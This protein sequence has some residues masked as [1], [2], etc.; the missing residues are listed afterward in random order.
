MPREIIERIFE[1]F[2]STKQVGRGTGLGLATVWHLISDLGGRVEVESAEGA[3]S[4]FYVYMPVRPADA[5]KAAPAVATPAAQPGL[6]VLVAEDEESIATVLRTLLKRDRHEVVITAN[7]RE[8]WE[9]FER[10]PGAF[11]VLLLDFNMPEVTGLELARRVRAAGYRGSLLIMSGRITEDARQQLLE[12][13]V[14]AIVE[15]P[16]TLD[17]IR[18]ALNRLRRRG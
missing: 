13:G 17:A 14:D 11:D 8:A 9:T 7:G 15:K 18:A 6:R 16:F 2:Y 10:R 3:G 12:T 1:P 4:T 5:A